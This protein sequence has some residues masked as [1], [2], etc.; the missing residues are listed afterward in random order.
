MKRKDI[1]PS[2][3]WVF[4]AAAVFVL[5]LGVSAHAAPAIVVG[6]CLI[7]A[8]VGSCVA[9]S[10][11][12]PKVTLHAPVTLTIA[13]GDITLEGGSLTISPEGRSFQGGTITVTNGAVVFD[14]QPLKKESK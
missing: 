11:P 13:S 5:F 14:P 4:V 3:F 2:A 7:P 1:S 9:F 12:P 10:A 6:P 8:Q